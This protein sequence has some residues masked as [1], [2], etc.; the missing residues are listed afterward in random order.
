MKKHAH[1]GMIFAFL[2]RTGTAQNALC[3]R[4]CPPDGLER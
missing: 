4:R 1:I 3:W 2:L